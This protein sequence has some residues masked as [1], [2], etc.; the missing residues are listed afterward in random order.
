ITV[1]DSCINEWIKL[2]YCNLC[3]GVIQ[4][5]ICRHSCFSRLSTCFLLWTAFDK[6]WLSFIGRLNISLVIYIKVLFLCCLDADLQNACPIY[7]LN[8]VPVFIENYRQSVDEI[9]TDS[10]CIGCL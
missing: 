4:P 3:S 2:R 9:L 6:Y 5:L 7:L 1:N 10:L 8:E